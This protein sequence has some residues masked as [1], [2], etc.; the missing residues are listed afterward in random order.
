MP[1]FMFVPF[2]FFCDSAFFY[3]GSAPDLQEALS[4]T[5]L[6]RGQ[7]SNIRF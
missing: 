5:V 7:T 2:L 6:V 3:P 4:L 1:L